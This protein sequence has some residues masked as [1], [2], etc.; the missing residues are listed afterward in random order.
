M[1]GMLG[2]TNHNWGGGFA[3]RGDGVVKL[4][5]VV[6]LRRVVIC[7]LDIERQG[8]VVNVA[9]QPFVFMSHLYGRTEFLTFYCISWWILFY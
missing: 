6:K 9:C 2:N 3:L 4:R 5:C 7:G 1:V 8:H